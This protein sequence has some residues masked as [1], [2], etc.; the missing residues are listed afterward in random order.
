MQQFHP[1]QTKLF[2]NFG[3]QYDLGTY[4][5]AIEKITMK[6]N[7]HQFAIF[8]LLLFQSCGLKTAKEVGLHFSTEK[9]KL[10]DTL[11]WKKIGFAKEIINQ[12]ELIVVISGG[13]NPI[14]LD[15]WDAFKP[16][17][18]YTKN[19]DRHL[20]FQKTAFYRSPNTEVNCKD[21][22][23]IKQRKYK[24]YT[25]VEMAKPESTEA[26]EL[27]KFLQ[28]GEV[29]PFFTL[30][31][32]T[33][34]LRHGNMS[35]VEGRLRMLQSLPFVCYIKCPFKDDGGVGGIMDLREI[36]IGVI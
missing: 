35:V 12:K 8:T 32:L 14:P 24:N 13:S 33:E 34:I 18:P 31:L 28:N 6:R 30:T 20:L 17:F 1:N 2:C 26:R 5:F 4:L 16:T 11:N 10:P 7:I 22:D 15:K 25:W 27:L 21:T 3:S 29:I 36:E 9:S 23:Y 19:I